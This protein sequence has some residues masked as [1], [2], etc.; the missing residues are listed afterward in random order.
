MFQPHSFL[1]GAAVSKLSKNI[2]KGATG[3]A[4]VG[5]VHPAFAGTPPTDRLILNTSDPVS[6]TFAVNKPGNVKIINKDSGA[7]LP[8]FD[9]K[10]PTQLVNKVP[11]GRWT[12]QFTTSD[13]LVNVE[14]PDDGAAFD[15]KPGS[16][17]KTSDTSSIGKYAVD[18]VSKDKGL[19]KNINALLVMDG[20]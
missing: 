1:K 6:I 10:L 8:G 16:V 17:T 12:I 9:P 3:L 18:L 7:A 5:F 14:L 4:L 2:L 13:D 11:S 20:D 15:F 19:S